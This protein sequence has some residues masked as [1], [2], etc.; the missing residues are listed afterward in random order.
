MEIGSNNTNVRKSLSQYAPRKQ[1]KF[2]RRSPP[3]NETQTHLQHMFNIWILISLS[4]NKKG[5]FIGI[6]MNLIFF[7]GETITKVQKDEKKWI[8]SCS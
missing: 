4:I 5:T 6:F 8:H 1:I 3:V 7:F 2:P